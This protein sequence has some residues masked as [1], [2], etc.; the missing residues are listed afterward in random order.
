MKTH[1]AVIVGVAYYH[2]ENAVDNLFYI[3][4]FKER[5]EDIS[6]LMRATGRKNRYISTDE[7]ET[8][9][10]MGIEASKKVIE[11]TNINPKDLNRIVFSTGTPEY[12][13]PCHAVKIHDAIKAGQKLSAYDINANCA[14]MLISFEQI[15]RSMRDNS[16][17]KYALI[18]GSEQVS[19]FASY[20]DT[21]TYPSFGDLACAI[22]LENIPNTDR[23]FIDSDTYTNSSTNDNILLPP[24]GMSSIVHTKIL[25]MQDKLLQWTPF[26]TTGCFYSASIS[27]KNL[28]QK[29]NLTK[30]D[31]KKYFLSQ[32]SLAAVEQVC[33]DMEEDISK[34]A[35]IGD[36]YGYT[37]TSS[38]FLAYAKSLEKNEL[39]PG[40]Y[41][42]FWTVGAGTTAICSLYRY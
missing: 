41:V 15:S 14:G 32:F 22:I 21:L 24:N 16:S 38:P 26:D 20:D 4:H 36:E 40:D 2:P 19:R 11:K 23:G 8:V 28:L 3:N 33:S 17:L 31:I 35:F 7:N 12:V 13:S 42:I 39:N 5:G 9:L 6:G 27:I 10:T 30:K 37:G 1:N 29:H 18:V 34:F 25:G